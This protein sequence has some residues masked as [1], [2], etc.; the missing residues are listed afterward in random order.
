MAKK[1]TVTLLIEG[2]RLMLGTEGQWAYLTQEESPSPF[3]ATAQA[4]RAHTAEFSPSDKKSLGEMVVAASN[5]HNVQ[6]NLLDQIVMSAVNKTD[7]EP[8]IALAQWAVEEVGCSPNRYNGAV[9]PVGLAGYTGQA[10]LLEMFHKHGADLVLR[11]QHGHGGPMMQ[12]TTLLQRMCMEKGV[13]GQ[14]HLHKA[15]DYLVK[16]V[17]ASLEPDEMGYTAISDPNVSAEIKAVVQS[18]ISHP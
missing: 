5:D 2:L 15:I 6:I 9:T 8:W 10:D 18:A 3:L 12:G 16:N 4:I 13:S 11:L 17:P 7:R 14:S 1:I